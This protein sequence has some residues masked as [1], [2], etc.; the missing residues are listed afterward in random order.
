MC[1]KNLFNWRKFNW[2][3]KISKKHKKVCRTFNYIDH[4]CIVVSTITGCIY[5]SAF[6]SLVGIPIGILS[7][8]IGLKIFEITVGIK[9]YK[10]IINKKKKRHDKIV[11]L[12]NSKLNSIKS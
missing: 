6:S 4:S 12:A 3:N 11:L 1:S 7:S 10:S 8:E 9:K 5:I 2:V